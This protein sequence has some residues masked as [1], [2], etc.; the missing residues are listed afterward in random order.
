MFKIFAF[1]PSS[2]LRNDFTTVLSRE[3]SFFKEKEKVLA[4]LANSTYVI[5]RNECQ[6][7]FGEDPRNVCNTV[8]AF[9]ITNTGRCY[10]YRCEK[11]LNANEG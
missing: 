2:R 4:F 1:I 10:T 9:G 11:T 6:K 8:H 7:T 3:E 5:L